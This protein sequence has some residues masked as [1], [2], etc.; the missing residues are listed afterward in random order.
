MPLLLEEFPFLYLS[1]E[2]LHEL[3]RKSTRQLEQLS[4]AALDVR[5]RKPKAQLQ[6]EE[7]ERRQQV[8]LDIMKKELAHNQRMVFILSGFCVL[9][10]ALQYASLTF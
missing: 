5:R 9:A 6:V 2:T 3:W 8:L 7:A 4:N 1:T 10:G